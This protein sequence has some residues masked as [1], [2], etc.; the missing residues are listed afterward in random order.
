MKSIAIFANVQFA[1][2]FF[3]YRDETT[4]DWFTVVSFLTV[5]CSLLALLTDKDT[6]QKIKM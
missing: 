5:G 2:A 6:W 3:V 1:I 4:P